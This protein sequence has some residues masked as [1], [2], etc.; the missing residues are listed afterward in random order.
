M[1][2]RERMR[3]AVLWNDTVYQ[4]TTVRAGRP[5]TVGSAADNTL[6]VPA[7]GGVGERHTLLAA[8]G[9]GWTLHLTPGMA[10]RLTLGGVDQAVEGLGGSVDLGL[11]DWGVLDLG[12]YALFVQ[13]VEPEGAVPKLP[14]WRRV[15]GQAVASLLA[16]LVVHFGFLLGAF[17]TWDV[18]PD[19]RTLD[20]LQRE[21]IVLMETPPEPPLEIELPVADEPVADDPGKRAGGE[22]GTF[23]EPDKTERSKL[24]KREGELTETVREVGVHRALGSNLLGRGPLKNVFGD[25]KGFADKLT[26]GMAGLGDALV[27]GRGTGGMGIRGT[28]TGGGGRGAGV[29]GGT[30]RLNLGTGRGAR[31]RLKQPKRRKP[32]FTVKPPRSVGEHC[33]AADIQRVVTARRRGITACYERELAAHPELGGKLGL[34]W[35]IG[36]DGTVQNVQVES[37]TVGN[38]S[39]KRCVKRAVRRWR[40][41]KPDGGLCQVRYP[42]VFDAGL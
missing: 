31:S 15:D 12:P 24:A 4:E 42:F 1:A 9:V 16:A 2:K 37:D 38:A 14:I 18:Q 21:V 7:A 41:P 28:G 40:F 33:A 39:F 19:L 23:G 29:I 11:E 22:Q 13:P 26:D 5:V 27:L 3:V 10:G 34:V 6:C 35:R 25:T 32:K 17:A 36:L 8:D 20:D 30:A